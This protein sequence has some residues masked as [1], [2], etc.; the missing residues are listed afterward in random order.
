[1]I[2]FVIYEPVDQVLLAFRTAT[3]RSGEDVRRRGVDG[4]RKEIW[5]FREVGDKAAVDNEV[6]EDENVHQENEHQNNHPSSR[7]GILD[8]TRSVLLS[9]D[10]GIEVLTLLLFDDGARVIPR[11]CHEWRVHHA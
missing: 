7:R 3:T 8:A 2:P 1:M 9:S 5:R 11:V 4:K 6:Y 10:I